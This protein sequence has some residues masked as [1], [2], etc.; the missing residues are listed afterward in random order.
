[1]NNSMTE[2][3]KKLQEMAIL[4]WPQF[5][6][7]IGL[8]ALTAAKVCLL[9]QDKKSYGEISYKLGITEHQARYNCTKCEK[10]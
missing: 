10:E 5:V 2:L 9:R 4:N 8:D 1:M 7:M 6:Q 3:D